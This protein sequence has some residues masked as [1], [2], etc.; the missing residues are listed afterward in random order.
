MIEFTLPDGRHCRLDARRDPAP[1]GSGPSPLVVHCAI[2]GQPTLALPL[3]AG[4]EE[5]ATLPPEVVDAI[6]RHFL[7]Q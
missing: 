6:I 1:A 4:W 5:T 2:D 7:L 3:H